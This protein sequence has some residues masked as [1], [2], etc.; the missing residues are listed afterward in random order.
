M[1]KLISI[2]SVVIVLVIMS[3]FGL[4]WAFHQEVKAETFVAQFQDAEHEDKTAKRDMQLAEEECFW[5]AMSLY[6]EL[7]QIDGASKYISDGTK[8]LIKNRM[9]NLEYYKA[10][11]EEMSNGIEDYADRVDDCD[12]RISLEKAI[13]AEKKYEA[14][15]VKLGE[16]INLCDY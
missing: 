10:A 1:K 13:D 14:A 15:H 3:V 16:Y 8:S 7:Q 9:P 11:I 5:Q 4:M 6:N 12:Y 2:Q